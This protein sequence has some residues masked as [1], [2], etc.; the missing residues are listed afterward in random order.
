[1]QNDIIVINKEFGSLIRTKEGKE[2]I[3]DFPLFPPIR[4]LDTSL[5]L[6]YNMIN[7]KPFFVRSI[8]WS[9]IHTRYQEIDR[10]FMPIDL[11]V[12]D[13][14][15][16]P[17]FVSQKY[18]IKVRLDF[19]VLG[20]PQ[21]GGC[22]VVACTPSDGP[23][24]DRSSLNAFLAGPHV[25]LYPNEATPAALCVPFFSNTR[26]RGSNFASSPVNSYI[27]TNEFC[28]V[29][30]GVM[31]PLTTAATSSTSITIAVYATLEVSEFYIPGNAKATFV[32]QASKIVTTSL[33][34][35][36]SGIKKMS[37]DFIDY[38]RGTIKAYTGL[39][40]PNS[41]EIS[42]RVLVANR[43][44]ANVTDVQTYVEKLDPYSK[45]QRILSDPIFYTDRDEMLISNILGKKQY[46]GYFEISASDAVG[47]AVWSRPITMIQ[48]KY[49]PLI[50]LTTLHAGLAACTKWWRGTIN[51]H[52]QSTM[53]NFQAC[54]LMVLKDY[55]CSKQWLNGVRQFYDSVAMMTENIEFSGGGQIATVKLPFVSELNQIQHSFEAETNALSHGMYAIYIVQPLIQSGGSATT[56]SFNVYMSMDD[57]AILYG[58]ATNRISIL[59]HNGEG[60]LFKK[61]S[62]TLTSVS[63]DTVL[64]NDNQNKESATEGFN[65]RPVLHIR[66]MVRR[67][68]HVGNFT[69]SSDTIPYDQ[70]R[71]PIID[72]FKLN[73][74]S[75]VN[76]LR[77]IRRCFLGF[78]GGLKFKLY[79]GGACNF[80]VSFL[81]PDYYVE[82]AV[83]GRQLVRT[84]NIY[85]ANN[86]V[87]AEQYNSFDFPDDACVTALG[88]GTG[89][90]DLN[91]VPYIETASI[92]NSANNIIF[93]GT[94]S[95]VDTQI[96]QPAGVSVIE[97]EVPYMSALDFIG[98]GRVYGG[99]SSVTYS[100]A[101]GY[102][103]ISFSR[104]DLIGG[105]PGSFPLIYVG[106]YM[107]FSDE[108]RLGFQVF[109]PAFVPDMV[110]D[111]GS[112]FLTG[113]YHNN[114]G[115]PHYAGTASIAPAAYLG[116]Y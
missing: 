79:L 65:M 40:N 109:A 36:A 69:Y 92:L 45:Y 23:T 76:Y 48:E 62:K 26:L 15:Q 37:A 29:V 32:P 63:D 35:L 70:I 78:S 104:S 96:S 108:A 89:S 53:N 10:L 84:S 93:P 99:S 19:Q 7:G 68:L 12:N 43:N 44:M 64:T 14:L 83:S 31:S 75:K 100:S 58:Y 72:L 105:S 9:D 88:T 107:A 30:F 59:P 81:P 94:G 38:A 54:K 77:Y 55:S 57:D 91:P 86:V 113:P 110:L 20:T 90:K 116:R 16:Y 98:D 56:A 5:K 103:L 112:Y 82:T 52:I 51:I 33:D 41:S 39:H 66:D 73:S 2:C 46:V 74:N 114:D 85:S 18:R 6:D 87:R 25:F 13:A 42:S 49:E 28:N 8:N 71:I 115:S 102:L 50:P 3:D 17:F 34:G 47:K 80:K 95:L 22:I 111:T 11:L 97:C 21:H 67:Y 61:E 60:F 1:M 106:V 27:D 101:M 4:S 24:F